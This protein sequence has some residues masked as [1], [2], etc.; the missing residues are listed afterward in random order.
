MIDTSIL[1][2]G[3][4]LLAFGGF[5]VYDLATAKRRREV[6]RVNGEEKRENGDRSD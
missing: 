6:Y 4:F 5:A 2:L 1:I 3:L